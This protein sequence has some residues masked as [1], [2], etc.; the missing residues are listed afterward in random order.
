MNKAAFP[1]KAVKLLSIAHLRLTEGLLLLYYH[2]TV[3]TILLYHTTVPD[4]S[5]ILELRLCR[6]DFVAQL[7]AAG[8]NAGH[9]LQRGEKNKACAEGITA[10]P[11]DTST[12]AS[13]PH[14]AGIEPKR[15]D[16][17]QTSGG[18]NNKIPYTSPA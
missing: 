16:E 9:L 15:P 5:A 11:S 1:N 10:L 7:F 17:K 14:A 2:T 4:F 3:P 18:R 13:P 12:L 6:G 8:V